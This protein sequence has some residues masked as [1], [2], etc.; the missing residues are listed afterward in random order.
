MKIFFVCI[1]LVLF[2]CR[3]AELTAPTPTPTPSPVPNLA[4]APTVPPKATPT[5]K[6]KPTPRSTILH[7][8]D[9]KILKPPVAKQQGKSK[10]N[11]IVKK[12]E[13]KCENKK[14]AKTKPLT[15]PRLV[16]QAK[17]CEPVYISLNALKRIQGNPNCKR[18]WV[19]TGVYGYQCPKQRMLA[20]SRK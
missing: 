6:P 18:V 20:R 14:F 8:S 2:G 5:P 19:S 15:R 4:P 12:G 3:G 10:N 7:P 11:R 1:L 13:C 17:T 16:S 9:T